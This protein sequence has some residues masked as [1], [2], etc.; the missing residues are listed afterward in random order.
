M[1]ARSRARSRWAGLALSV[2]GSACRIG[3]DARVATDGDV[4]GAGPPVSVGGTVTGLSGAGLVLQNNGADDLSI[5]GDGSFTFP[6]PVSGSYHVT[7]SSQPAGQACAV[8]NASGALVGVPITNVEVTCF[9]QGA[10]PASALTFTSNGSFTVP[11]GCTTITVD[12]RGGGGAGGA[13]NKGDAAAA[14][15]RGGRAVKTLAGLTA[16]TTFEIQIGLGGTCA[17]R[18]A[19]PGGY[20]GGG[21]GRSSG[22]G[23]GEDGAGTTAPPGG[24]GGAGSMGGQPGGA[25]GNGGYGGGGGGGGGDGEIGNSAGGATTFALAAP[26]TDYVIAGGGG[27]AGTADQNGDRSGPGGDACVGYGGANGTA[28]IAGTRS[29]GGGGGG[30]CFCL[31]GCDAAPTPDGG[32]AGSAGTGDACTSAEHGQAGRVVITFP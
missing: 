2:L 17:S 28:A 13:K 29:G 7:V 1:I 26:P 3:F 22:F 16:G 18:T 24:L 10:C 14:G 9:D 8:A 20:T 27:A 30:A 23:D 32:V 4:D 31:G 19:T 12:A 5:T 25:G 6:T 21:G 15:G 11:S